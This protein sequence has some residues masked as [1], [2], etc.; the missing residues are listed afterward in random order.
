MFSKYWRNSEVDVELRKKASKM[1]IGKEG[2]GKGAFEIIF[3]LENSS[4]IILRKN[5]LKHEPNLLFQ[6]SYH[7]SML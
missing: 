7:L 6:W 2:E 5:V 4:K 3:N 1:Q